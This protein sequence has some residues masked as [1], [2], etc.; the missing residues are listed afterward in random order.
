[1]WKAEHREAWL[2]LKAALTFASVLAYFDPNRKSKVI[3]DA[4]PVELSAILAQ[5]VPGTKDWKVIAYAN[6]ALT[7]TKQRYAQVEREAVAIVYSVEHFHLYLYGAP[8]LVTD[9]KPLELIYHNSRPRPPARIERWLLR[10]ADYS[11]TVKPGK[12]NP[13]DH[14]SRHPGFP[15]TTSQS[16]IAEGYVNFL[17][18]YAMAK[19]I[20]LSVIEE[21]TQKDHTMQATRKGNQEI[22]QISELFTIQRSTKMNS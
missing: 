7:P 9:H 15:P 19:A 20:T 5:E 8:E 10:R 16:Q 2:K 18:H 1:M 21:E 13:S 17:T 3:P 22:A 11:F 12:E 6:H 4:S 14:M